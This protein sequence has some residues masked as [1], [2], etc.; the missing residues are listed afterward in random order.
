MVPIILSRIHAARLKD[1][2][3]KALRRKGAKKKLDLADPG[4]QTVS[5]GLGAIL[6]VFL[7]V[8]ALNSD[9][10]VTAETKT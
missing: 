10:M 5:V 3:A 9:C 6:A 2:N 7:C 4:H 1:F 8:F